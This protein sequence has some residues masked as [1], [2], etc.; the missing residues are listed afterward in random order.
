MGHA[1][2]ALRV[3]AQ[4]VEAPRRGVTVPKLLTVIAALLEQFRDTKHSSP[5]LEALLHE[6]RP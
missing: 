5:F 4:D 3:R 2:T 6:L 1:F